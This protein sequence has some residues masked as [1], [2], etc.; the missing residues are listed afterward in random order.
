M[1]YMQQ[2][3]HLEITHCTEG[4]L[5]LPNPLLES[6]AFSDCESVRS[7]EVHSKNIRKLT[8]RRARID[9][10]R[11]E[12]VYASTR[13]LHLENLAYLNNTAIVAVLKRYLNLHTLHL[14]TLKNLQFFH[15][16]LP[17]LYNLTIGYCQSL[18]SVVIA[19]PTLRNL[20]IYSCHF[21]TVNGHETGGLKTE[22]PDCNVTIVE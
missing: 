17:Q 19:C 2:L 12:Q 1:E 10:I 13:H 22:F 18:T 6:I 9:I 7:V 8:F 20:T 16:E 3:R 15:I 5:V 14:N 21:I 11:N 4:S